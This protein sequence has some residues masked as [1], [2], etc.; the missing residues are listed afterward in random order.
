MGR[1]RKD[2]AAATV[3]KGRA[4][5]HGSLERRPNGTWLARWVSN[6]KRYSQIIKDEDGETVTDKRRAEQLLEKITAPYRLGSEAETA[7]LLASKAAGKQAELVAWK[8]KQP[9][10]RLDNACEAY[11]NSLSRPRGTGEEA[12]DG[13]ERFFAA[14]MRWLETNRPDYTEI[15][16]VTQADADAYAKHLLTQVSA[17]TFNKH[18]VFFRRLWRVLAIDDKRKADEAHNPTERKAKLNGN[19]WEDIQRQ[20]F[21]THSRKVLTVEQM[22]KVFTVADGDMRVLFAIGAYTGLRLG[23]CC[24][25]RWETIDWRAGIICTTPRKTAKHGTQV[26]LPLHPALARIL[27]ALPGDKSSGYVLPAIA[28]KYLRDKSAPSKLVQR[29]FKACGFDTTSPSE[30][31]GGRARIDIGFHSLRHTFVSMLGNSGASLALVQA[32][33]GHTSAAMTEHYFHANDAALRGS[34]NLLPDVID[35]EATV[36]PASAPADDTAADRLADFRKLV[37][38]MTADERKAAAKWLA[39]FNTTH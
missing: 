29:V 4:N 19:P 3:R 23:D 35:I 17:S 33:V 13:Y 11:R 39:D 26:K 6:G 12:L 10:L 38:A 21:Q 20:E 5:G 15:R 8:D 18:L 32:M 14:F 9:A 22:A 16:E 28:D 36:T 34:V 25:L 31:E 24:L 27:E 2:K 37:Q 1:P 7:A 30:R